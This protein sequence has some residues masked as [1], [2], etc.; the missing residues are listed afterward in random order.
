MEP[1][2]PVKKRKMDP[3][4]PEP[5]PPNEP[6][7]GPSSFNC[8][9]CSAKFENELLRELHI[10]RV[11]KD[12]ILHRCPICNFSTKNISDYISHTKNQH[13]LLIPAAPVSRSLPTENMREQ[14]KKKTK[15]RKRTINREKKQLIK[16]EE[17]KRGYVNRIVKKTFNC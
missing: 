16:S 4:P 14:S 5:D 8:F 2:P 3:P 7:A 15:N 10:G 11:H 12:K 13:P 17:E 6:A 1:G 9:Y